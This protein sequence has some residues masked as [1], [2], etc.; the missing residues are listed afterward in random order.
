MAG[1]KEASGDRVQKV[2]I[3]RLRDCSASRGSHFAQ[4]ER[5][6]GTRWG[7]LYMSFHDIMV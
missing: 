6:M 2:E 5:G 1:G 7:F 3:L 4:D